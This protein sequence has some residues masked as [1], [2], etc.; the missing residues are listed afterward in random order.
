MLELNSSINGTTSINNI[1]FTKC[2]LVLDMK[3]K[4]TA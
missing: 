1:S 4:I 2:G 3:T